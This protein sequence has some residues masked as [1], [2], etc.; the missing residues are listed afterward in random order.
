MAVATLHTPLA[1]YDRDDETWL[2]V[3]SRGAAA[4]VRCGRELRSARGHWQSFVHHLGQTRSSCARALAARSR[5]RVRWCIPDTRRVLDNVDICASRRPHTR[6]PRTAMPFHRSM[7]ANLVHEAGNIAAVLCTHYRAGGE[8]RPRVQMVY[9]YILASAT[10][11]WKVATDLG[12]VT[13]Q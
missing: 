4:R 5:H 11:A 7:L 2:E 13:S 8:G 10:V 6:K 1:A 9:T 3:A 12:R